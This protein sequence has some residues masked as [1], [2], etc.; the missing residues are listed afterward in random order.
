MMA[1]VRDDRERTSTSAATRAPAR[2]RP[3][4][5]TGTTCAPDN[6]GSGHDLGPGRPTPGRPITPIISQ[7]HRARSRPPARPRWSSTRGDHDEPLDRSPG[8]A[9]AARCSSCSRSSLTVIILG[10]G[11]VV[12][13]GNALVQRRARRTRPTS[14]PS[15]ARGSSPSRSAATPRTGRTPTSRWRSPT[16]SPPTAGPPGHLRCA[17]W[18]ALRR[19]Q[20]RRS[21]ATSGPARSR[22]TA[23][24]VKVGST[25]SWKPYFLGIIGIEQ[26]DRVGRGD[27]EGRLLAGARRRPERSSRSASRWRSSRPI[28]FCAGPISTDPADPCYPQHLTP[29]QPERAG[30]LRLA[31]VRLRRLRARPGA[32]GEH[33]RLREQQ[34]LPRRA[35]SGR[36]RNSYGCCT[37][38][39]AAGQPRPDRQ[40]ARQQGQRR[41][42]ATT[43]T[44]RSPSRSR[45]GTPPAAPARTPGT[46]SSAS[47]ASR[48]PAA[49]A[50]RTSRASGARSFFNGPVT[51]PPPTR[52]SRRRSASSS[53]SSGSPRRISL[54]TW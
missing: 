13:G 8:H 22:P 30:R 51:R 21:S 40:P 23:V 28:P 11:L 12:D 49:A 53:S 16:R 45:S 32:A 41:L 34:A 20:W 18:P 4:T 15:P 17:E 1:P 36:R 26:L 46:T 31:E 43:S 52:R 44:T 37:A 19:Q 50:A 47:P 10:V 3:A 2:R 5:W 14:R 48:S 42:L 35:R 9:R 24:G 29:G 6:A 39:G 27:G 54:G 25:A 33:R 7:C 38:V